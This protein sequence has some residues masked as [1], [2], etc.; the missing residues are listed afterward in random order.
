MNSMRHR[1]ADNNQR[2]NA[3]TNTTEC[4]PMELLHPRQAQWPNDY[5]I[6]DKGGLRIHNEY[7]AEF[8]R[9]G[10]NSVADIMAT[11]DVDV[12]RQVAN[13]DNCRLTLV[14]ADGSKVRVFLKRH[15]EPTRPLW[16]RLL[17]WNGNGS[18]GIQEADQVGA[19][20]RAGVPTMTVIAAGEQSTREFRQSFFMSEEV[21]GGIPADDAWRGR[22]VGANFD[23]STRRRFLDALAF[24]AQ[25]LHAAHLYHRDFY[26]CHFLVREPSPGRFVAHLIDLQRVLPSRWDSWRWLLKDLA[27]FR[28]AFPSNAHT[29]TDVR[30]WFARYLGKNYLEWYDQVL[31]R[32]ITYRAELYRWKEKLP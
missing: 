32:L 26:W 4:Q 13:R 15:R 10:W 17:F 21:A 6:L 28:V 2:I 20:Q 19:C 8:A 12:I 9:R 7:V 3:D 16:R 31:L 23:E 30:Y 11:T 25:R 5:H 18:A 27:Q 22:C 29:E 24:T 14:K 1:V